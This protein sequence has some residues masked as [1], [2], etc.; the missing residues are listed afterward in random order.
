M[1]RRPP[2]STRLN[3]LFPYTTLFRSLNINNYVEV[4]TG[5]P[6]YPKGEV[7]AGYKAWGLQTEQCNNIL[8]N[9][10]PIVPRGKSK[11]GLVFNYLSFVFSGILFA[12]RLMRNKKVDVVFIF[13]TSP[14]LQA[15]PAI[16]LA[17]LKN[18]PVV[19]WEIG[20]ASCR[21]RVCSTV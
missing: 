16:F 3:T 9:R 8:I 4:V 10:I 18:V 6:N 15:I 17:K 1:I 19:V 11:L 7:Y 13:A 20:R 12:P 2:R 21:E 14:L 5:K